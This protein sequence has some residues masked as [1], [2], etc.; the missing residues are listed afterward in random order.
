M[1]EH[2]SVDQ[3]V[4]S[5]EEYGSVHIGDYLRVLFKRR[6]TAISTFLVV[7][8]SATIY[9]FTVT[10]IYRARVRLLIETENP[11]VLS[12]QEVIEQN[13][14]TNDY[15]QT[16]Y[17]ILESRALAQRTLGA[18]KLWSHAEFA[19]AKT[20]NAPA[21]AWEASTVFVSRLFGRAVTSPKSA[22]AEETRSQ[23][24]VID[25]FLENLAIAPVR[26]SRLVDVKYEATDPG[27]AVQLANA[28]AR[29]FIDQ[30]LEFKF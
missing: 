23:A 11:N 13:K 1:S 5:P 8:G 17:R 18:A 28:H 9:T 14:T 4:S 27:L 20:P 25:K 24:R 6:W 7:V 10:P 2:G 29:A 30:N 19:A 12:F 22:G 26:N 3:R 15:Y 16:Q 21:R